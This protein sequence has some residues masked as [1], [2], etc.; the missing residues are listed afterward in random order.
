VR[1]AILAFVLSF[2]QNYIA[3]LEV[4]NIARVKPIAAAFLA[5]LNSLAAFMIVVLIV[6]QPDRFAIIAASV[7]ADVLATYFALWRV[8][9]DS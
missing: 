4:Y 8:R 2:I 7:V 9:R 1:Y 6:V 3:T 5:L